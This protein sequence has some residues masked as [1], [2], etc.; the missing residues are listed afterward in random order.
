MTGYFA[1]EPVDV[2]TKPHAFIR[3]DCAYPGQ[4]GHGIKGRG[5][6][7]NGASR[8]RKGGVLLQNGS[9]SS[10]YWNRRSL[11]VSGTES[12]PFPLLLSSSRVIVVGVRE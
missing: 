7:R 2:T 10:L 6:E 3:G 9:P 12:L 11:R 4:R 1:R 8:T 5:Q